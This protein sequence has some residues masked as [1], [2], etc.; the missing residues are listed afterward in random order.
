VRLSRHLDTD[1]DRKLT[2]G[3]GCGLGSRVQDW[4][5]LLPLLFEA[6]RLQVKGPIS[7]SSGF[8][9][10]RH[11]AEVGGSADSCHCTGD[12]L[13]LEAPRRMSFFSFHRICEETI[14]NLTDDQGGVGKYPALF[15]VHIDTG[16]GKQTHRRWTG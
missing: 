10:P 4:N 11:N 6:I 15:F 14:E 12:A 8:R 5:P 7:V 1:T 2:C 13:D 16:R 3:C 9:C